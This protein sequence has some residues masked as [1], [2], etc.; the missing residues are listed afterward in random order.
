MKRRVSFRL[1]DQV[2]SST[3]FPVGFVSDTCESKLQVSDIGMCC[4]GFA[5]NA[6][7]DMIMC[8]SI[9]PCSLD[10]CLLM[11]S[12]TNA[13]R[14]CTAETLTIV[15]PVIDTVDI[16]LACGTA[17]GTMI[18]QIGVMLRSHSPCAR[19]CPV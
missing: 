10:E 8:L 12:D 18:C 16:L 19:S 17:T 1:C 13:Y 2:Y 14:R 9:S 3:Q 15:M 6:L 5:S 7:N 4:H 11:P